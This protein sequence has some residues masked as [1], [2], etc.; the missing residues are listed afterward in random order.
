MTFK[1]WTGDTAW[2]KNPSAARTTLTVPFKNVQLEAS[3]GKGG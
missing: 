2:L 3:F 1:S